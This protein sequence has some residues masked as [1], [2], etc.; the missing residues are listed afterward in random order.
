MKYPRFVFRK[1]PATVLSA[2][3]A[4]C[5]A[6]PERKLVKYKNTIPRHLNHDNHSCLFLGITHD[7]ALTL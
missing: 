3:D 5:Q 7:I 6:F 2:I 4:C 1:T